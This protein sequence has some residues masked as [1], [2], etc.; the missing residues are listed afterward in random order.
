MQAVP[1]YVLVLPWNLQEE[2]PLP[3]RRHPDLGRPVRHPAARGAVV[4]P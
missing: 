4:L 1:D 3:A 2:I